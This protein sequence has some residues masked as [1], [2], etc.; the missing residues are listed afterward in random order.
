MLGLFP[1]TRKARLAPR[2]NP[3][4][5]RLEWLETRDCPSDLTLMPPIPPMLPMPPAPPPVMPP[6]PQPPPSTPT[7]TMT[8]NVSYGSGHTVTLSGHVTDPNPQGLVVNFAGVVSG[9]AVVDASGNYQVALTATSLGSIN[10]AVMG[11]QGGT[12]TASATLANTAAVISNFTASEGASNIWTFTGTLTDEFVSGLTVTFG[13]AIASVQ[14]QTAT[15]QANGAFS[16]TVQLNATDAG[17]VSAFCM[18]WWSAMS[19]TAYAYV[20]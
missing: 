2:R 1:T 19:N 12:G 14:G 3:V 20:T 16:L 9:Q 4:R 17:M 15:V 8:L 11:S 13:G 18:D 7:I 6:M 10:A 5:L